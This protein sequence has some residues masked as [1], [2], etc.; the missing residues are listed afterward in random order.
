[1]LWPGG[2]YY[3]VAQTYGLND[4]TMQ[5]R[6]HFTHILSD[7]KVPGCPD[8][9]EYVEIGG[10]LGGFSWPG[11]ENHTNPYKTVENHTKV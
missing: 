7:Q 11:M 5:E 4:E 10:G 1:M 6:I 3:T 9:L 8:Q 2:L